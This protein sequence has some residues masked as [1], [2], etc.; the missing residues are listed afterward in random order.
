MLVILKRF[1][2]TILKDH[3]YQY[4]GNL[5]LESYSRWHKDEALSNEEPEAG[6]TNAQK[7]A[8]SKHYN[9]YI[10]VTCLMLASMNLEF[11]KQ[12]EEMDAF[13]IIGQLKAML[14]LEISHKLA[15]DLV[16]QFIP[17]TFDQFV[18]N[19]NMHGMERSLTELHEML[20]IAELNIKSSYEVLMVQKGKNPKKRERDQG[21]GKGKVV[22]KAS[23]V[24]ASTAPRLIPKPKEPKPPKEG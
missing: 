9:D 19:H 5:N 2:D 24:D 3:P 10:D 12:F 23:R 11:Q 17:N 20:K 8:Y 6:A 22:V 14:G 18:M 1:G 15:I 13:A 21:N 7:D 16:L 4:R